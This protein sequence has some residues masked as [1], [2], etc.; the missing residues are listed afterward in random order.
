[1]KDE[2]DLNLENPIILKILIQTNVAIVW[3]KDGGDFK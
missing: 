2:E 3:R 1:L